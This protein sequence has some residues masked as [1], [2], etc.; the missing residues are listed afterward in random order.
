MPA[1]LHACLG[2]A[3][4][5]S[6]PVDLLHHCHV[7]WG[8][9]CSGRVLRIAG[10]VGTRHACSREP[11]SGSVGGRR[12]APRSGGGGG[13]GGGGKPLLFGRLLTLPPA[14]TWVVKAVSDVWHRVLA[15][16]RHGVYFCHHPVILP[17]AWRWRGRCWAFGV[18]RDAPRPAG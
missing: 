7:F 5:R 6:L 8:Q 2:P 10:Y 18:P 14:L 3:P 17:P 1:A 11:A 12:Q 15:G 9:V 13:G 4:L 16:Q